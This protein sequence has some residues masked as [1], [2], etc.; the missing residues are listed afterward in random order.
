MK[1]VYHI[2]K[3]ED[4][5][6]AQ[7]DGLYEIG[8][9]HRSFEQDGFIHLAYAAQVNVIADLIY[10]HTKEL[11]LLTIDPLKLASAIKEERAEYPNELFPHLYGP[12]NVD[13]VVNV[14]TYTP[15]SNGKFP[16]VRA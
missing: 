7:A 10:S 11:L 15:L 14:S 3:E 2:A 8:S 5:R 16:K 12:L 9:L 4:W 1:Y 13:A 6:N